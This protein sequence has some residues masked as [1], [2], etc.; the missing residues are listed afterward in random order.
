MES[1]VVR[2]KGRDNALLRSWGV[3]VAICVFTTKS[4]L[5]QLLSASDLLISSLLCQLSPISAVMLCSLYFSP[6]RERKWVPLSRG[7]CGFSDSVQWRMNSWH[8][9]HHLNPQVFTQG[10]PREDPSRSHAPQWSRI[11][12][13]HVWPPALPSSMGIASI[14]ALHFVPSVQP[15]NLSATLFLHQLLLLK[16]LVIVQSDHAGKMAQRCTEHLFI[17]R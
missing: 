2:S 3:P 4:I 5:L 9:W 14:C 7:N 15:T 17:S 6:Q 8:S 1:Y 10:P 16:Q 11:N 13:E 12:R